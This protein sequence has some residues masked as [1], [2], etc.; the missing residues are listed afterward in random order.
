MC[1][2]HDVPAY[3]DSYCCLD[4]MLACFNA[5]VNVGMIAVHLTLQFEIVIGCSR[6]RTLCNELQFCPEFRADSMQHALFSGQHNICTPA[7]EASKRTLLGL[8][9]FRSGR[10]CVGQ[11]GPTLRDHRYARPRTATSEMSLLQAT[12]ARRYRCGRW[13]WTGC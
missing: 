5:N 3:L 9:L 1:Q 10:S 8:G 4:G 6:G 7:S 12:T 13:M 11:P 2:R